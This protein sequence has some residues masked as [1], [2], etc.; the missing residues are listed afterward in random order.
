MGR[1]LRDGARPRISGT[2]EKRETEV[3]LGSQ[4]VVIS[5]PL[6]GSWAPGTE[7]GEGACDKFATNQD[8]ASESTGSKKNRGT[9]YL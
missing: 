7:S 5:T 3:F 6:L 9:D 4:T 8:L 2:G 1:R